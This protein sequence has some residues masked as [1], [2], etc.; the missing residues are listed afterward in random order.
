MSESKAMSLMIGTPIAVSIPLTIYFE[1][2]L[3]VMFGLAVYDIRR[4]RVPNVALAFFIPFALAFVVTLS[5]YRSIEACIFYAAAG[6]LVGGIIPLIT[7]MITNGGI[8]GGDIKLCA[9]L[10]IIAGPYGILLI[11]FVATLLAMAAGGIGQYIFRIKTE[12]LAF[13][14]FL[15]IGTAAF[16]LLNLFW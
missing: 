1:L 7:A 9:L 16:I 8:G 13:V 4:K 14:P 3:I 15:S 2:L 6:L 10:G 12:K 5:Q 11:L